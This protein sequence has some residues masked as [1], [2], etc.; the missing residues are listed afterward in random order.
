VEEP[1][2]V[3]K[4]VTGKVTTRKKSGFSKLTGR[5]IS[6]DA[7]NIKSYIVEDVIIPAVKNT[8]LDT[9]INS[10]TIAFGGSRAKKNSIAGKVS[11]RNF[12]D[13][14]D[15][16]P[17]SADRRAIDEPRGRHTYDYEEILLESRVEAQEVLDRMDELI[18]RYRMVSVGDLYDLVGVTGN[19]TDN[20]YGWTDIH[21]AR[22][23]PVRGGY[24][25]DLPR[26]TAL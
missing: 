14:R 22:V 7:R 1:K 2:K 11:Y 17:L 20:K 24:I 18:D 6:D 5:I 21:T 23:V 19:Y 15:I 12:Y 16:S 13:R 10:A 25:L 26:P 4:I 9:I 3:E 8:I